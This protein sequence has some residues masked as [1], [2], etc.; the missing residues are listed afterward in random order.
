MELTIEQAIN[1][2]M[3]FVDF[4]RVRI[5][6][7]ILEGRVTVTDIYTTLDILQTKASR[8][9]MLLRKYGLV[10]FAKEGKEVYYYITPRYRNFVEQNLSLINDSR[11]SLDRTLLL[12][13]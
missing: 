5:L 1:L 3:G 2:H 11:L 8:H 9:L 13:S 10:K 12:K 6:N 7:I 4:T